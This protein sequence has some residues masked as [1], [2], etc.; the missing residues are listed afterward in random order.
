M[1]PGGSTTRP[2]CPRRRRRDRGVIADTGF[3]VALERDDR[4]AW[5]LLAVTRT[6]GRRPVAPAGVLA[7]AWRGG[8]RQAR[9]AVALRAVDVDPMTREVARDVGALLGRFEA[10]DV[11]DGHVALLARRYPTLGVT[12]GDRDDLQRLGVEAGRVLDV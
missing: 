10:S 2:A 5:A 12:S 9:L 3:L 6:R 8:P 4:D 7:Q 11:V 1:P